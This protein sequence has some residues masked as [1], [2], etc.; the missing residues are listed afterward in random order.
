MNDP[1]ASIVRIQS[2]D[3]RLI[4]RIGCPHVGQREAPIL[5]EEI[6][7]HAPAHGHRVAI[8]FSD[9]TM[10]GSLGLGTL[11]TLTKTCKAEK[12]DLVL[13][14]IDD[15]IRELVKMSR[16]DRVLTIAE[17]EARAIKALR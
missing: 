14:A 3:G 9:V 7:A 17:D 6:L 5:Q 13:F 16:L 11:I 10:L 2:V 4:A 15:M 1:D 12:G 8:D